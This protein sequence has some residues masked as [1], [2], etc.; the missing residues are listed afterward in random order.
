MRFVLQKLNGNENVKQAEKNNEIKE[1]IYSFVL[2]WYKKNYWILENF[3]SKYWNS[4]KHFQNI[5]SI[6]IENTK[7]SKCIMI[8][9]IYLHFNEAS[10]K[11]VYSQIIIM[12]LLFF[13]FVLYKW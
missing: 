10:S 9:N 12:F 5:A 2:V 7:H 11:T 13:D 3:T 8:E 6:I 1:K 4:L